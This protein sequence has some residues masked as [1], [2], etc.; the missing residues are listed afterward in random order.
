MTKGTGL[1][2]NGLSFT[3]IRDVAIHFGI[4][5]STVAR[6]LRD[7]WP[8][9]EALEQKPH[10]RPKWDDDRCN[11][12]V[13][14]QGT[15]QTR[16]ALAAHFGI[17]VGTLS[18]RL[19][20]NWP[21]DEAVGLVARVKPAKV[22]TAV[23]CVSRQFPNIEALAD[24][25][26][27]AYKLVY[28]RLRSGWTP[29]QAVGIASP[30]PRF[31]NADGSPRQHAWRDVV[32]SEGGLYPGAPVGS[33]QLYVITNRVNGK[34]YVGITTSP[35]KARL[36][37]HL[38]AAKRGEASRLYNAMRRYGRKAFT[39]QLVRDDAQSFTC[40][41]RQEV[42]EI[43]RRGTLR[44]GYNISP[45]GGIGTAKEVTVG[46]VS[47]PSYAACAKH[48]GI[49]PATFNLRLSRLGWPAEA[50]AGLGERRRYARRAVRVKGRTFPSLK[51]ATTHFDVDYRVV[52]ARLHRGWTL[53]EAF[54][55]RPR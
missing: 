9:E 34:E 51:A 26:E 40:L 24:H 46:G 25:Y 27:M 1:T 29:E 30:P 10:T 15:F 2:V 53:Q 19:R 55:I 33:F 43:S 6:R 22:T 18:K 4:H 32:A 11:P 41:Q 21:P 5:P 7:G 23:T 50:A 54:G 16:T 28:K 47:F 17:P 3:T 52:Y 36:R 48:H 45:G 35:L 12:I 31:R 49:D 44:H 20:E 14:S 42:E 37:G 13:T 39:I 8:P 38:A